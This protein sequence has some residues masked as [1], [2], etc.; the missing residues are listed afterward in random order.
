MVFEP[1][2]IKR[3]TASRLNESGRD[4][5]CSIGGSPRRVI[6]F[7]ASTK[8]GQ[9]QI[10]DGELVDGRYR[11]A[12]GRNSLSFDGVVHG[13]YTTAPYAVSGTWS[14]SAQAAALLT[15]EGVFSFFLND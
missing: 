13:S 1:R 2:A 8:T 6:P 7:G 5:L 3:R 15:G 10:E 9:S 4:F 11:I 14:V 12:S